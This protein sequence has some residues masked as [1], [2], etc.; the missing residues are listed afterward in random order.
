ML[1]LSR[2]SQERIVVDEEIEIVVLRVEGE[3]V[4]LGIDAPRD[5]PIRR[6]ELPPR[7]VM[8]CVAGDRMYA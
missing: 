3:W 8:E 6:S 5:V 2:R 1:V 4:V 7:Q